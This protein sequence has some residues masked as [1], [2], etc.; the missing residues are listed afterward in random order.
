M[1][2]EVKPTP[3]VT[4]AEDGR[5]IWNLMRQNHATLA[6]ALMSRYDGKERVEVLYRALA[7]AAMDEQERLGREGDVR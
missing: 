7:C 6:V 2:C 5:K 3:E 1:G 4:K